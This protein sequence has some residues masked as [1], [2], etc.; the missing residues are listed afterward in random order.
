MSGSYPGTWAIWLTTERLDGEVFIRVRDNGM[1]I[2]AELLPCVFDLF[3]QG[4]RSL[5]RSEGGLGIG[6]TLVRRLVELHEGSVEAHSEGPGK[7]SEFVVRLPELSGQ[8]QDAE[9]CLH[10]EFQSNGSTCL[11]ILVVEDNKDGADSLGMLLRIM[12]H[13]VRISYSASEAITAAK[14]LR[15]HV[16]L[17]DIGLPGMSGYEVGKRLRELPE[18]DST[19][20]VA[21]TGYGQEEDRQKSLAAGFDHHLVKPVASDL[22]EEFLDSLEPSSR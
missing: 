11:N 17:I 7:G 12:G 13:Q 20:L 10:R 18:F 22:L 2:T 19:T 1:G 3:T 4:D 14:G 5:A 6:L 8:M 16:I 9:R 21:M 15:P